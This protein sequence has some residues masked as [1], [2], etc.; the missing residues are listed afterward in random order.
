[1]NME[2]TGLVTRFLLRFIPRVFPR[3]VRARSVHYYEQTPSGCREM[4]YTMLMYR[5][6][7]TTGLAAALCISLT[8][9]GGSAGDSAVTDGVLD[10]NSVSTVSSFNESL[11]YRTPAGVQACSVEDINAW[12]DHD[13]RDY[14]IYNDQVPMVR[15][16]DYT[17]PNQLVA[18]LRVVPDTFSGVRETAVQVAQF[19]EGV[20][21]GY[22]FGSAYTDDGALRF[23]DIV[24]G[25]PM[26]DAGVLR[27]DRWLA[28]NGSLIAD[29]ANQQ[30]ESILDN[31]A[32]SPPTFTVQTGDDAPRDVVVTPGEYNIVTTYDAL[33][34]TMP[35]GSRV[36]Y[37]G[38]SSFLDRTASDV[39]PVAEWFS[40]NNVDRLILDLRYNG[41]G[42]SFQAERV[43]SQIVGPS[44]DGQVYLD[45]HFNARYEI[46]EFTRDFDA[47]AITMPMRSVVILAT[48]RTASASEALA[49]GLRPYIDVTMIG[50]TT[51]GK[52]F[53]SWRVDHCDLS[54]NAQRT[55][56][57]NANGVTVVN[58][59][60]AD[61][62][63][64][65]DWTHPTTSLDDAM[66]A[67]AY[68]YMLDGTC[69]TT[70]LSA[71]SSAPDR[72]GEGW[73]D[74][75]LYDVPASE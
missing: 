62:Q 50:S 33:Y 35:D 73:S 29:I 2:F 60:P 23:R 20:T 43:A 13:M 27:G 41:G 4:P 24:R 15:L 55:I 39:D 36:G 8:A 19:D 26:H 31:G 14:Y 34:H 18:D 44:L 61:C 59:M 10:A 53:A 51:T 38:I 5:Q 72:V 45:Y 74:P 46:D 37:M 57:S 16:S 6:L 42:R 17:D 75:Y 65:D 11:R 70:L 68:D 9:C 56:T 32:S 22:G 21:T 40:E 52:P 49:N 67:A 25:S 1:M 48:N 66:H 7:Q 12:I 58:G 28:L 54:L 3:V 64:Q 71:R 47:P 30:F 69:N 63:V